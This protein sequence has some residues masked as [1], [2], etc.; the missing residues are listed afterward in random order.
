MPNKDNAM[1][2]FK[3]KGL[4]LAEFE[5]TSKG[6]V[7]KWQA[8]VTDAAGT[9]QVWEWNSAKGDTWQMIG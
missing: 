9:I 3:A 5:R 4:E 1:E 6:M 7:S 2:F 8:I